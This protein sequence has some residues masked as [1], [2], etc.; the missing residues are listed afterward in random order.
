MCFPSVAVDNAFTAARTPHPLLQRLVVDEGHEV[1]QHLGAFAVRRLYHAQLA[2]LQ[3]FVRDIGR[4]V[5]MVGGPRAYG[6][7]GYTKTKM[8]ELLPVG[9]SWVGTHPLFGPE[10]APE[11]SVRGQRIVVC[12][13]EGH[14]AAARSVEVIARRLGLESIRLD[15][16]TPDRRRW[17]SCSRA[18]SAR[19][20]SADRSTARRRSAAYGPLST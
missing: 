17:S 19:P 8:E 7:G 10:S 12:E 3:T 1:G 4:G 20:A 9:V 11:R 14:A 2:A 13:A 6:A 18:R 5:V 15:P 16:Q